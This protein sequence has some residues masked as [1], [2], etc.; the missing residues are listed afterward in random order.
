MTPF[1]Y[2][3]KSVESCAPDGLAVLTVPRHDAPYRR[4]QA[5]VAPTLRLLGRDDPFDLRSGRQVT[6][7][8]MQAWAAE[9]GQSLEASVHISPAVLPWPLDR[10]LPGLAG[11]IAERAGPRFGTIRLF[12]LRRA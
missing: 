8:L 12:M 10:A 3:R 1:R 7:S 4:A 9:A 5:L 2:S 6:R 11:T